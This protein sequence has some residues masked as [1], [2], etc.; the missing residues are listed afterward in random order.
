MASPLFVVIGAVTFGLTV[1]AGQ[2]AAP[3]TP[4]PATPQA[5]APAAPAAPAEPRAPFHPHTV[6]TGIRGGY[7]VVAADLNKDGKVDLI[8]LGSNNPELVWYENPYWTPHVI[9][10][11]VPR[12]VNMDAMDVDR[13]GIPEIAL[14]YGFT[15][16]PKQG[17]SRLGIL[18]ANG[19]PREPWSLKEIDAVPTSHRARFAR[20]G[21]QPILVHA[22]IIGWQAPGTADPD[23]TP[24]PLNAYR[25]PEWKRETITEEN[26]GV[27]H[28]LL[29]HDW[30]GDRQAD[31]LTAGYQGVYVYALTKSGTWTR[32]EIV[33]GDSAEWPRSGS[34][35]IAVGTFNKQ[36]FL[37][38]NEPFHGNQVVVYQEAPKGAWSRAVIDA[39]L[40]NS[41]ALVLIDADGDG[42]A[43]IVSGGTR[44]AAR[45]VKPGVFFYKA[46]DASGQT[47]DR[48][49]LDPAIAAN[50]CVTADFNGDKKMDLACIDNSDPWALRWYE[51]ARK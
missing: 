45:G 24:T 38:T 9:A 20:I 26:L 3:P 39:R 11:G 43:E 7:Q 22:P 21:G 32:T 47:W 1:L 28:D 14:A 19:D 37:A 31:L 36:R 8:G 40:S 49:S 16:N 35:E 29:I 34:S 48:L 17:T 30:D 10:R 33:K 42:N 44:G 5:G 4:A 13:D 12:M 27:V 6:A 41:H 46:S 50:G 25:P 51:N 2:S 23:R 15:L 18:K